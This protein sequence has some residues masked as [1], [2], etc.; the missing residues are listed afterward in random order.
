MN[1]TAFF[2][3]EAAPAIG[4]GHAVRSCVIADALYEKGWECKIVTS[5]TSYRFVKKLDRF[6]YLFNFLIQKNLVRL[7]LFVLYTPKKI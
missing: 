2:R 5:E 4:A 1:K 3:F 6:H 7:Y